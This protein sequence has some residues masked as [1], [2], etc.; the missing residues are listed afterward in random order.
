MLDIVIDIRVGPERGHVVH[1]QHPRLQF[2]VQHH[3]E[4]QQVAAEVGLFGLAGPVEVLQLGLDYEHRFDHDLLYF[5]PDLLGGFAVR[6]ACLAGAYKFPLE[7]VFEPQLVFGGVKFFEELHF[8]RFVFL[9]LL[10]FL[11]LRLW[12]YRAVVLPDVK[13]VFIEGSLVHIWVEVSGWPLV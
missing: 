5:V 12:E 4:A 10:D 13:N 6:F 11:E 8:L 7:N 3:V 1:F 9:G 2:V